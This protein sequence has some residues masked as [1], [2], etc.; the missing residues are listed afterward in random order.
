MLTKFVKILPP[1]VIFLVLLRVL[2]GS[3]LKE[4]VDLQWLEVSAGEYFLMSS[5][6]LLSQMFVFY[7]V[8]IAK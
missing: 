2:Q 4:I 5:L 1:I 8:L 3:I 7:P 6:T